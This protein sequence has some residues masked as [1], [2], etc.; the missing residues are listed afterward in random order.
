MANINDLL[1]EHVTLDIQCLDRIY[2]NG[3]VPKLQVP[4]QLVTFLVQRGRL[5]R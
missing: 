1:R 3:Y 2:V 5:R 4:G